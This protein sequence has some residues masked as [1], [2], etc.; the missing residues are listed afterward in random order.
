[1][2]LSTP[3]QAQSWTGGRE[4]KTD[5]V[6]L[7]GV[8]VLNAVPVALISVDT[9]NGLS[10]VNG[11]HTWIA[12]GEGVDSRCVRDCAQWI[13]GAGASPQNGFPACRP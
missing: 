7:P 3:S 6:R 9:P 5:H 12:L 2:C 13:V 11:L 10:H 1:M 8:A 4:G